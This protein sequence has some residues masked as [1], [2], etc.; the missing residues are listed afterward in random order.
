[1]GWSNG[2]YIAEDV[3][4]TVKPFIPEDKKQE[5]AKKIYDKFCEY[6]ADDWDSKP[7]GL[8]AIAEPVEYKEYMEEM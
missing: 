6:D 8:W 1:M 7:D 5:I 2:S 4:K 3:W